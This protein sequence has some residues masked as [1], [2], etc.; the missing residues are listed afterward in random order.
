M[1][2][3][4]QHK[5]SRAVVSWQV[6]VAALVLSTS[7]SA[8]AVAQGLSPGTEAAAGRYTMSP[9]D[10]GFVRLDTKTGEMSVCRRADGSWACTAMQDDEQRRGE[11][12]AELQRENARLRD[13]VTRLEDMLG[14]SPPSRS[15]SPA[16]PKPDYVP[17]TPRSNSPL[18]QGFKLP[19]E[20]QVEEAL[21]YFAN[22]L[23]K[24]QDRLQKLEKDPPKQ[25]QDE[26]ENPD[27]AL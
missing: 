16:D 12:V 4:S 24:F 21:D 25:Q 20:R 18:G 11:Q 1:R 15:P 14:L 2:I 27:R 22:I 23:K 9:T 7:L 3:V 6:T 17:P 10:G 13:E 19:S 26:S 5:A 8:G